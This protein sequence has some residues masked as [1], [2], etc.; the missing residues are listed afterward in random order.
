MNVMFNEGDKVLHQN[1]TTYVIS[2]EP[3]EGY[4]LEE[5]GEPY[6]E[7]YAHKDRENPIVWL[8]KKSEMEDGR[9]TL[10]PR[11]PHQHV[12]VH[13]WLG[14]AH[15]KS[16]APSL[17]LGGPKDNPYPIL[18]VNNFHKITR[19]F[20]DNDDMDDTERRISAWIVDALNQKRNRER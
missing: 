14:T 8:R 4:L 16:F 20:E 17:I 18:E 5:S 11:K 10:V 2:V 7:Y 6:Y 12:D 1:G 15:S 19:G 13:E 9:F 3:I